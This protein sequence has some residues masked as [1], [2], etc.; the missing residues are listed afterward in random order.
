MKNRN[1]IITGANSGIG[2]SAAQIFAYAG[3]TVVIACRNLEKGEKA[4]Q[5]IVAASNNKAVHLM[6]VDMSS[7][8]S[9][10]QFC[11]AYKE[12]FDKLDILI[13]N[14]GYFNHGEGRRLSADGIEIT[15]ATNVVGPFLLTEQLKNELKKS[16]DPRV[17]NA[18]SNIIKHYFSP[19]KNID[20]DNISG[21]PSVGYKH[22]VYANYR[23]SKMAFLML[24]FKMAEE[25]REL[26]IAVNSLQIT[27]AR[28]SNETLRK[29]APHWRIIARIQNLFF[30]PTEFMGNNYFELCTSD[31]FAN[32]T[33]KQFN[34]K[35]KS[36]RKGPENPKPNHIWG[37]QVYPVYA[38]NKSVQER[39][40][41]LCFDL[42]KKHLNS[43]TY[44]E[45]VQSHE[46]VAFA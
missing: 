19:K 16:D 22:S 35:L 1:V 2:K 24:S 20:L 40:W 27:G 13:N 14:A 34:H 37:S 8:A 12:Q 38:T 32:K 42:T 15:F 36:M 11:A 33:G 3:Y 46:L 21:N 23:D 4:L 10:S 26:G 29:F 5:E 18:S 39:I 25:Y 43:D 9:I 28:M 44:S 30:P 45:D 17:L 7:L 31:D 41:N 6:Q